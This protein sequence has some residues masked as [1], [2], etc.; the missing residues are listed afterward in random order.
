M[1][2]TRLVAVEALRIVGVVHWVDAPG[3][4]F[5]GAE[6]MRMMPGLVTGVGAR[7]A[8]RVLS[9]LSA[10]SADDP[11]DPHVH[12]GPIGVEPDVQ[13]RGVGRRLMERYC[14][15]LDGSGKSGYLE[16]D[17]P[18][19]VAFYRRFEFETVREISVLGVPN[20]LMERPAVMPIGAFDAAA[21][22]DR[23]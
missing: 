5:S 3:C 20:V 1:K 12:L 22:R 18:E 11:A 17:R 21:Q 14:A 8:V 9:W 10:W 19:N 15:A 2:G 23:Q 6:K 7:C 13:G 16:T 4:Q